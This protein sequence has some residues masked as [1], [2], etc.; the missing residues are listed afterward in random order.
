MMFF[1]MSLYD[2]VTIGF[3]PL[4][5]DT[6]VMVLPVHSMADDTIPIL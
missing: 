6:N 3:L 5:G 1:R 4:N 2:S